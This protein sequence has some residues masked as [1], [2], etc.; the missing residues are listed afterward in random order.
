MD[1][2]A[3]IILILSDCVQNNL[4]S[5]LYMRATFTKIR[6]F[7]DLWISGAH[8]QI[9]KIEENRIKSNIISLMCSKWWRHTFF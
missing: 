1:Y 6:I 5:H 7:P 8:C 3:G 2:N 4:I 9:K